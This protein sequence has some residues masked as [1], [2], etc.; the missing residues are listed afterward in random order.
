VHAKKL[1]L[2]LV[3]VVSGVGAATFLNGAG[4][5][6]SIRAPANVLVTQRLVG[7]TFAIEGFVGSVRILGRSGT[8]VADG[9]FVE[10]PH[11]LFS[12][13]PGRYRLVGYQRACIGNCD[14][15]SAPIAVCSKRLR[16]VADRP[17]SAT[18]RVA[19][20]GCRISVRSG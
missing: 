3:L 7:R 16:V 6:T 5:A 8:R 20:G 19:P 2:A 11:L 13:G 10:G 15:L 12:L 14:T 18:V 17:V 1:A 9:D 4:A